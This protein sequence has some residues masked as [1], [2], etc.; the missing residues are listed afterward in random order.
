MSRRTVGE[1]MATITVRRLDDAV[2][3]RLKA[4]AEANGRSVESEVRRILGRAV[5]DDMDSKR[6]S[7]LA[8]VEEL[9]TE[10]TAMGPQTPSEILIREDRDRGHRS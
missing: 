2:W 10:M 9:R 4:R 6:R 3:R 5:E 8:R 7:F 1:P